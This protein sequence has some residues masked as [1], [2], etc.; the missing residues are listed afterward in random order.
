MSVTVYRSSD[1]SAPTLTGQAGSLI[2]LLD[3][4]L[5][6][7]YGSK[8]A[9]GWTKPYSGTNLAAYRAGGGHLRYLRVD[10]SGT[11]YGR[12]RGFTALTSIDE[13]DGTDPFPTDSIIL[14]GL[15]CCKSNTTDAVARPWILIAHEAAFYLTIFHAETVF[16]VDPTTMEWVFFGD[17]VGYNPA[18]LYN[19]ALIA[20][21]SATTSN[22]SSALGR[23]GTATSSGHYAARDASGAGGARQFAVFP[24]Y[25]G[26]LTYSGAT[27]PSYP[28]PVTGG[29]LLAPAQINDG[30]AA[31]SLRG[32]LP[33][34]YLPLHNKPGSHLYTMTM[35][36][37]TLLL[38][39]CYAGRLAIAIS[40]TWYP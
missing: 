36:S 16:S 33:G 4:C 35:G 31:S 27:G 25:P 24:V 34:L 20:R 11:Q 3:A 2:A 10:D 38:A 14:G 29:M 15:Y 32:R 5:V 7:G 22:S 23:L 30:S 6:N 12:L 37:E 9:A 18:D 17:I 28:D 8:L 1:S 26:S 19:T 21:G 39:N 13:V 40:D